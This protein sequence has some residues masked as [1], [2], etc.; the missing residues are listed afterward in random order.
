MRGSICIPS[1]HFING[2]GSHHQWAG[3]AL[4]S[5]VKE[6][7]KERALPNRQK[8]ERESQFLLC[9]EFRGASKESTANEHG[10]VNKVRAGPEGERLA[11]NCGV[12][13]CFPEVTRVDQSQPAEIPPGN[14]RGILRK[15]AR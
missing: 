12:P 14:D 15:G 2:Q 5:M 3:L 1:C 9:P 13:C 7:N 10:A 11:S 4:L 6:R 8:K